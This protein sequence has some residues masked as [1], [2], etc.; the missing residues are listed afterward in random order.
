MKMR[1]GDVRKAPW[2]LN[3]KSEV[4]FTHGKNGTGRIPM[5]PDEGAAISNALV[6]YH[7]LG[8]WQE[9]PNMFNPFWRA[10]LHPFTS[11]QAAAVLGAAGNTDAAQLAASA[12]DL[13]L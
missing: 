13:P 4:K 5:A 1:T 9:Q 7:R 12:S 8:D 11:G 2:E 6:Y 3:S 10:K